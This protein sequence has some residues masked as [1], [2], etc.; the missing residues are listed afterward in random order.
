MFEAKILADSFTPFGTPDTE[1]LITMQMTYPRFVHAEH[2]RHRMFSF[3]VASSRA[4]PVEKIIQQVEE[5]PVIPIHWGAAQKGMQASQE[6]DVEQQAAAETWVLNIRNDAVSAAK[7][8]LAL[9]LHKQ[10]INRY[11]EP[12]MWCTVICTGNIGA[13]NNFWALRCHPDAEPHIRKIAEMTRDAAD[14]STPRQGGYHV[15]LVGEHKEWHHDAAVSAGRCA[16]VS[17]LTHEG[18]IDEDADIALHD[19]LIASKHFSPTE[20]QAVPAAVY[21][22][23][24]CGNLGQGWVQYR[25]TLIGEYQ[26]DP[27]NQSS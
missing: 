2:L 16:R 8:L 18:R 21:G 12:W 25:K 24:P 9:G 19:R 5:S 15:P 20:H 7:Y 17:Y 26:S 1:R 4:I 3:N 23:M 27:A 10:V 11:L 14:A 22:A 6:I 13:W